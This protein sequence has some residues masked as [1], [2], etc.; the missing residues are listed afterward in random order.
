MDINVIRLEN[1]YHIMFVKK[2]I[3][4]D[5]VKILSKFLTQKRVL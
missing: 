4:R 5:P 2:C 3:E 1:K